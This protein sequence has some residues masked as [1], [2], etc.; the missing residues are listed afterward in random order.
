MFSLDFITLQES[1]CE[2]TIERD[3]HRTFPAHEFFAESGGLGQDSLFRLTKAYSVYD[4]E[5]GYCQGLS[6][7]VAALLL[8][9][10]LTTRYIHT[11]ATHRELRQLC[12][13]SDILSSYQTNDIM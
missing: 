4:A 6:F 13:D 12:T 8:H 10:S 3:L 5:I 9:V 7:L 2:E 11:M 1:P